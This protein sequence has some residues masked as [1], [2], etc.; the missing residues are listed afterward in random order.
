MEERR[1]ESSPSYG[2]IRKEYTRFNDTKLF[3][4][5]SYLLAFVKKI[6]LWYGTPAKGD[7]NLKTKVILGIECVYKLL[8]G[9]IIKGGMHISKL[10][11][12]D[13]ITKELE[14]KDDNDF[15][16]KFYI[17]FDDIITY[18][19][20]ES[21]KGEIIEIGDCDNNLLKIGSFNFLLLKIST[22]IFY[23]N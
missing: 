22:F 7:F 20:I 5:K 17:C 21:H 15:F 23:K 16:T 10:E 8:D 13:I 2:F 18:I 3:S 1:F 4:G 9:G 19:K 6:K 12:D 11:S 14:L